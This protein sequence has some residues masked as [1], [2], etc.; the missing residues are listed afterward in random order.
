MAPV[1]LCNNIMEAAALSQSKAA[2]L[3]QVNFLSQ[4]CSTSSNDQNPDDHSEQPCMAMIV[5]SAWI[6][7]APATQFNTTP[8]GQL[9]IESFVPR[10]RKLGQFL[11]NSVCGC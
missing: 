7:L 2:K 6:G 11:G 1:V 4:F 10:P 8:A 3:L 5:I 9:P